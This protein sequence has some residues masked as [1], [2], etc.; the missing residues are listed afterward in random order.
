MIFDRTS[1]AADFYNDG[2]RCLRLGQFA[3]AITMLQI[4]TN[5]N[6]ENPDAFAALCLAAHEDSQHDLLYASIMRLFELPDRAAVQ[7][8]TAVNY[9][10]SGVYLEAI[11]CALESLTICPDEAL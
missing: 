2:I 9:Y 11:T 1:Q 8:A 4:S 6:A 7:R 5:L 10:D 3:E